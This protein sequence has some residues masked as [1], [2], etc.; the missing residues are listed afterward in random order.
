[1]PPLPAWLTRIPAAIEQL[2]RLGTR[3][4][5]RADIEELLAISKRPALELLRAVGAKRVGVVLTLPADE[6]A[7]ALG[8]VMDSPEYRTA[9]AR[10][11]QFVEA[12]RVTRARRVR[13]R[14]ATGGTVAGLP[15]GVLIRPGEIVVQFDSVEEALH[16]LFVLAQAITRDYD[17]FAAMAAPRRPAAAVEERL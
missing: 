11:E 9:S 16:R 15:D 8:A 1:M 6:L 12:L 13:F 3:L 5:T 7:R 14:G 17:G 4:V 2:E 10:R